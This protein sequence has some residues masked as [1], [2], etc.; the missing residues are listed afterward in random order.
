MVHA[1]RD[2]SL[3]ELLQ[4]V[5]S[6]V[7]RELLVALC[8]GPHN[9]S[10]LALDLELDDS[11]ISRQLQELWAVELLDRAN[12]GRLHVY[13]LS[14]SVAFAGSE[15][16][17]VLALTCG[18]KTRVTMTLTGEIGVLL[19]R[20]ADRAKQRGSTYPDRIWEVKPSR[21]VGTTPGGEAPPPPGDDASGS[22]PPT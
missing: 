12:F 3:D 5:A 14:S 6:P 17:P 7:R 15:A 16:P 13:R 4:A 20:Y 8:S 22:R 9:V 10:E 11:Q 1:P 21:R 2:C 19:R 18:A